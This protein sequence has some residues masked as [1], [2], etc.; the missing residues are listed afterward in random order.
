MSVPYAGTSSR[1]IADIAL[2]KEARMSLAET[3]SG[4]VEIPVVSAYHSLS[5]P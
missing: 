4:M 3:F 1:Y 5:S 2:E